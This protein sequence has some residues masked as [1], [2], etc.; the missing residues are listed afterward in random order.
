MVKAFEVRRV[1]PNP[2]RFDLKKCQAINGSHVRLL[3]DDEL[4]RRLVPYF[5][6]AG[7]ITDPPTEAQLGTLAASTPL[8]HE[9]ITLLTEAVDMLRFLFVSDDA[10]RV[11]EADRAKNLDEAGLEVVRT[12]R[13]ILEPIRDWNT[14]TIE[15]ALRQALVD[16]MQL[17]PRLAFGPV[18]VAATGSRISPPLFES[19]ELLGHRRTILRLNAALGDPGLGADGSVG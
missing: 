3:T 8:V 6:A 10:F 1:N 14:G 19:L 18:R 11:D 2:A 4:R 16:G 13:N 17:K 15:G 7:L 5:Q 12:A 9:R